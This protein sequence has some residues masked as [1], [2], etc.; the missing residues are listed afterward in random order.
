MLQIYVLSKF[1]LRLMSCCHPTC[2]G[3]HSSST[4]LLHK[5]NTLLAPVEGWWRKIDFY[6][7]KFSWLLKR[8]LV[9]CALLCL[10]PQVSNG[11]L[12]LSRFNVVLLVPHPTYSTFSN[13]SWLEQ[14]NSV[15][16]SN[17]L[18]YG[19]LYVSGGNSLNLAKLDSGLNQS[20]TVM[21]GETKNSTT[22]DKVVEESQRTL[23]S[24]S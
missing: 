18:E 19:Y 13:F 15:G 24:Y 1:L 5:N 3:Q 8:I 16:I 21:V 11:T 2:A 9:T 23:F 22:Y 12:W 4:N 17:T 10:V 14:I 6:Q 20:L 7:S